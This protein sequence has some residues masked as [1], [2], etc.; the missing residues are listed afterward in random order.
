MRG[1][2]GPTPERPFPSL[3]WLFLDW[4]YAFLP[5]PSDETKPLVYTDEQ[6][7]RII[8][9]FEIHPV[10]GEYVHSTL[11]LEEAK[12]WGKSPF[13]A[14]LDIGEFVGP[15]CFDGWDADGEPVGVPWGTGDRR[16]PWI[17]IAATAI[18]QTDNTYG[19][20]YAMLAARNG[21]IADNLGIDL[22][23]TRLYLP[24]DPG[25]VLEPV[26]AS[27]GA[28]TGQPII[29]ATLDETWLMNRRNGGSKLASTI[30]FNL[31]KTN[32]RSVETTNAPIIGER[33]VAEQ[34]DPDRPAAGVLH[35]AR[36][37][38]RQPDPSWTDEELEAE[39]RYVYDDGSGDKV[40]PWITPPRLVRDIRDPRFAWVDSLR[41][42]FN[43]RWAGSG[44][45]V[46]PRRWTA[47]A[48]PVDVPAGTEIG[49]GFDGSINLDESW[50]RGCTR[51]GYRFTIGRWYRPAGAPPE[52]RVPRK[53][54]AEKLR[55]ARGYYRVGRVVC[56][57]FKWSTEIEDWTDEFGLDAEGKPI[58]RILDTNQ[59]TRFAPAVDRWLT[60]IAE[61]DAETGAYT[62]DGDPDCAE[63]VVA[64]HLR[65]VRATE[66]EIDGRTKYVLVKGDD[67]GRID[68][69]VADVLAL[70]AAM[71][72]PE[73]S[74]LESVY[75]TRGLRTVAL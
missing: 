23:R 35:Y 37:P 3:G 47:T 71:T 63:H 68:G 15:V 2:R 25:A 64:A 13:A 22:G 12:G 24:H 30:R 8:R 18:D 50:L 34:S 74:N 14:T 56:D 5:N 51:A 26:T 61:A 17:Q 52:W 59:E 67:R 32:G 10:S 70:E 19:A 75:E 72:M 11:I 40:I 55:W 53:E 4:S 38:R 41:Q 65:R 39:L 46:D 28:R 62:H 9:W 58:V 21:A 49:I 57:P 45:A 29:K 42:F 66:L 27:S 48:R 60:A 7:R 6:A 69:A 73:L 43:L 16:S 33:S 31:A 20:G 36:R 44:V 54:V 1:W